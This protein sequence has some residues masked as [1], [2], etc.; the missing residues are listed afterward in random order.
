MNTSAA[1]GIA[2]RQRGNDFKS[3]TDDSLMLDARKA[4]RPYSSERLARLMFSEIA[5][6]AIFSREKN[7]IAL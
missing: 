7:A 1:A 2:R 5:A 3:L 4:A 6:N